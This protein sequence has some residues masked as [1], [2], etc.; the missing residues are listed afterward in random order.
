MSKLYTF[1]KLLLTNPLE[2]LNIIIYQYPKFIKSDKLFLSLRFYLIFG[3]WMNW[4]KPLSYSEKLQWLKVYNRNPLYTTLV[5]KH[6]V[7]EWVANKIGNQHIIPTIGLWDNVEDIDFDELPNQFVLKCTHDSGGLCICRD[8]T[9]L[10]ILK[11]K[12]N[13]STAMNQN[14]YYYGREWPYKKVKPQIIAEK[15][16]TDESGIELKDYKFFCFNGNPLYLFVATD[17]GKMN[18]EVKFDFYDINFNHLDLKNGHPNSK[19]VIKKPKGF[20]KMLELAKTLS[21]GMPHVRIDFY[22]IDGNIYFG[23]YTFY[24][25]SGFM[26]FEPE[27]WDYKFGELIKLPSK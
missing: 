22:D 15:Y 21:T 4:N 24:H 13:L 10:N 9:K 26:P 27:E 6:A 14:Y 8:K 3:R 25:H 11:V 16:M 18:E 19:N 12:A 20:D 5:D 1:I 7:K 23:E 17:R 2:I